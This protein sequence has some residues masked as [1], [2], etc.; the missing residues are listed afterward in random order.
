[1]KALVATLILFSTTSTTFAHEGHS[2]E[3]LSAPHG[4]SVYE[5]KN[6]GV[7]LVQ[8][9]KKLSLYPVDRNWKLFSAADFQKTEMTAQL[10]LRNKKV[11][12]LTCLLY[13]S[14]SPQD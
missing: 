13:T 3:S 1:M 12:N 9:G 14:P 7:E 10:T 8:D 11:E 5:G 2:H 4:G 6:L